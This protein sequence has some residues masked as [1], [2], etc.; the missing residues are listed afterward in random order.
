MSTKLEAF[1]VSLP[2]RP[3]SELL[4]LLFANDTHYGS[5]ALYVLV[6]NDVVDAGRAMRVAADAIRAEIDRRLPPERI[7]DEE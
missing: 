6:A 3:T 5:R 1:L 7:P 2:S 4:T